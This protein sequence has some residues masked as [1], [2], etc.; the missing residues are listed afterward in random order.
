MNVPLLS[1]RYSFD[2]TFG[3]EVQ[4]LFRKYRA[5]DEDLVAVR[6]SRR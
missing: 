4:K 1:K 6:R 5:S 3:N 2:Y